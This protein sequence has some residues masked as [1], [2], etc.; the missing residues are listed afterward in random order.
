MSTPPAEGVPQPMK[1]VARD[2]VLTDQELGQIILAARKMGGQ[3]GGRSMS[4]ICPNN[5]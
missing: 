5:Q 1:E 4:Y 3:Y 2:R